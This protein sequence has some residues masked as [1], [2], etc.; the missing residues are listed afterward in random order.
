MALD[1]LDRPL[2]FWNFSEFKLPLPNAQ[3]I[4]PKTA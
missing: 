4:T 2:G 1:M 3:R